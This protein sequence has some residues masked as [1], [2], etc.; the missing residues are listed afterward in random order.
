MA[1]QLGVVG[2]QRSD[3]GARLG[4]HQV[5]GLGLIDLDDDVPGQI[6]I[7]LRS[8]HGGLLDIGVEFA[9]PIDDLAKLLG[10][11]LV[12]REGQGVFQL[13]VVDIAPLRFGK[14]TVKLRHLLG[15]RILA[16]H[17][18][19]GEILHARILRPNFGGT[20]E[21]GLRLGGIPS[22]CGGLG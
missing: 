5:V 20:L 7:I 15:E 3:V 19:V 16:A 21:R 17:H 11:L 8:Q 14:Q 10:A 13:L 4:E 2:D 18:L 1:D 6:G 22:K 12:L 9:D